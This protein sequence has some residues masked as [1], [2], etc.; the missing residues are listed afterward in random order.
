MLA[1]E[2]Q[3]EEVVYSLIDHYQ[4]AKI[5][6]KKNLNK[7]IIE[8]INNRTDSEVDR[9]VVLDLPD[10][11]LRLPPKQNENNLFKATFQN[12]LE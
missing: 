8:F 12:Y 11:G 10:F 4:P 7:Q 1:K 9:C 5:Y 2:F 6:K 3:K